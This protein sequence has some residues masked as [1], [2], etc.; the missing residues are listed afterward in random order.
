MNTGTFYDLLIRAGRVFCAD[1]GFDGPGAIGIKDDRIMA[2]GHDVIGS[3]AK[4]L[5]FPDD[6]LLP[7]FVDFHA[8]PAPG[9][10]KYGID[11]DLLMLPRG[12]TTILSQG[13]AGANN[14]PLY[15]KS[16][17]EPASIRIR[18]AL[19]P[20][21][22][23]EEH[24]GPVYRDFDDL[25]ID[26]CVRT[27]EE[28]GELI[29][30][31][32]VNVATT[33]TADD[34]RLVMDRVLAMADQTGKPLLYG[35]R[36]DPF[37][38]PVEEQLS[39]LRNGDVVTYSFHVGP[40]GLAPSGRV[41]DAAWKAKEQGVKFDIGHGMSSFDFGVAETA[42]GEGFLPDSISTDFYVRHAHSSPRHDMPRTISKL[43]A[44]GM[45]EADAFERATLRPAQTLGLDEEAGTLAIGSGADMAVIR[46]NPDAA[47]LIDV[48]GNERP[49][50]CWEPVLTVRAGK[51]ISVSTPE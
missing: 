44:V 26:A 37:D 5:E 3:A 35:V 14:W 20:A 43:L 32:A 1:T 40:G 15:K 22:N 25:D 18:M 31:I 41:L 4:I 39:L 45:N 46:W 48:A 30:G 12:T 27:I 13:D 8:H 50:G 51:V 49:G 19:S 36:W 47:P 10:W 7:G 29:W 21:V 6:L 2:L 24:D 11:P 17:I 38:W 9:H 16:I 33:V 42:V 34:A 28:D 23:G